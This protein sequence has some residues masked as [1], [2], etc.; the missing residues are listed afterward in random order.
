[1]VYALQELGDDGHV[2]CPEGDLAPAAAEM[3]GVDETDAEKAIQEQV[4]GQKLV[5]DDKLDG[6]PVY[7]PALYAAEVGVAK[8]LR[9]M[10]DTK[11]P[12]PPIDTAK[13]LEWVRGRQGIDLA[14]MQD[15][16]VQ[17]AIGSKLTVITGGPGVGKT[18]IVKCLVDIFRARRLRVAL[19]APTGRAAKRL[20]EATGA[21]AM[22]IHRL[23]KFQPRTNQFD[24]NE[25]DPLPAD[26]VIIDEASMLDIILTCHLCRALRAQTVFVLV[27]DVD[28]LPSVGPGNVLRDIIRSGVAQVVRLT[29]IFRQAESSRIVQ[30]AHRIN[31][32][33]LPRISSGEDG[34]D[35]DFFF[36]QRDDPEEAAET[37]LDLCARRLPQKYGLDP[38]EDIQVIA[39]MHRGVIGAQNLNVQLQDRLNP[40]GARHTVAGRTWRV[41]DKVMQ[42]RN[43][44][45]KDVYNGDLG[46][47]IAVLPATNELTVRMD[48][49]DLSYAV[50]EMD[51]VMPAYAITV[52]KSQGSEYPCVVIPVHT[53][54]FIMLQRNLL[55][56]AVTRGKR[57]VVIVGTTKAAAI[58]VKNDRIRE[59]HSHLYDRLIATA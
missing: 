2:C 30:S 42:I 46:R 39:P 7:I 29:E 33:Q 6:R 38:F 35:S 50:S 1:V 26:V 25:N 41:G 19:G 11:P 52:H 44:Y 58:A 24:M 56:T 43:N 55:Y 34:E 31:E 27:G 15:E 48:G 59:R 28:Q 3:L 18:T 8:S 54:H 16:A 37:I 12:F 21:E 17:T 53:Q 9:R 47:V 32:G 5:R 51:E 45:D 13:A 23:L 36:L 10:A 22:T 14:E 4:L 20:A 49:R 57:L 40:N